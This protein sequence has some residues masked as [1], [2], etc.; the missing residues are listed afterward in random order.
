[1]SPDVHNAY[2]R[3][4]NRGQRDA[5]AKLAEYISWRIKFAAD[6]G[7]PEPTAGDVLM[8]IMDGQPR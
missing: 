7:D 5:R 3:G 6:N 8:W 2:R 4:K 1:M